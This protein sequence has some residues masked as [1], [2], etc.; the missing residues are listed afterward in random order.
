ML[1]GIGMEWKIRED[2]IADGGG[3]KNKNHDNDKSP[4]T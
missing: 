2:G 4:S 3:T 1:E